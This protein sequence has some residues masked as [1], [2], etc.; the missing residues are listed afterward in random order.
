M[1]SLLKKIAAFRLQRGFRILSN[2]LMALGN[3][4]T[5]EQVVEFLFFSKK[6]ALVRPWQFRSEITNL[7]SLYKD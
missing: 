2:E 4:L 1:N 6:G 5:A 3:D 7:L